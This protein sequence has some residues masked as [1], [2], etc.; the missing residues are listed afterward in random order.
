MNLKNAVTET[1]TDIETVTREL[2]AISKQ[3]VKQDKFV[4][5]LTSTL[6]QMSEQLV[7]TLNQ[8]CNSVINT[9]TIL[10]QRS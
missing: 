2:Q 1:K 5:E 6:H 10:Q 4:P 3:Q 8:S 9:I 7:I